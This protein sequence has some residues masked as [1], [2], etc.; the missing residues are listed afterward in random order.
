MDELKKME[1]KF[2][3]NYTHVISASNTNEEWQISLGLEE[4]L[5]K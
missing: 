2:D 5:Y 4:S 3:R 1:K